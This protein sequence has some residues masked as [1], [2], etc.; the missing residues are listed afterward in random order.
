MVYSK[1]GSTT[2]A[3]AGISHAEALYQLHTGDMDTS[4]S[5]FIR[6]RGLE[7]FDERA[8]RGVMWCRASRNDRAGA[9]REYKDCEEILAEELDVEPSLETLE[10]YDAIAT[11]AS[12][13]PLE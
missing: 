10:L 6:A 12:L 4:E 8:Y 2:R 7:P 11:G 13:P 3:D 9:L 5:L 1:E